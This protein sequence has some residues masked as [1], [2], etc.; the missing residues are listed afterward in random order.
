VYIKTSR[1]D[2]GACARALSL[3][4]VTH[5]HTHTHT[6]TSKYI[7]IFKCLRHFS[8]FFEA[9][10]QGQGSS[11]EEVRRNGIAVSSLRCSPSHDNCSIGQIE[12]QEVEKVIITILNIL[13]H[14]CTS[15]KE[16]VCVLLCVCATVCVLRCVC[17]CVCLCDLNVATVFSQQSDSKGVVVTSKPQRNWFFV[18]PCVALSLGLL[19]G[20]VLF[21][22]I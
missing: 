19:V 16:R 5:T 13:Y 17:V 8:T 3:A 18:S 14:T 7:Y 6:H 4:L 22:G 15:K 10:R 1:L 9:A 12:E 21:V 20:H 2:T 11:E